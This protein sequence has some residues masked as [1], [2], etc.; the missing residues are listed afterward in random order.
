MNHSYILIIS[1][2]KCLQFCSPCS[3]TWATT[4]SVSMA[5][6][7]VD[8]VTKAALPD[9]ALWSHVLPSMALSQPLVLSPLASVAASAKYGSSRSGGG[10]GSGTPS[11]SDFAATTTR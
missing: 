8:A 5:A 2:P 11:M 6:S 4:S 10:S 3:I 7:C 9:G 1:L